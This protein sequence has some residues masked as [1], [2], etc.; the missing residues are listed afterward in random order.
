MSDSGIGLREIKKQMTRESIADAALSLA[1]EKGLEEVTIEEIA[2]LAF[3]SPRTFSNYFSCKE[4]A[5]AT[6][7]TQHNH[8]LFDELAARPQDEAPLRSMATIMVEAVQGLSDEQ[9]AKTASK[10]RLSLQHPSLR[11]FQTA[12]YDAI[13]AGLR[14]VVATRSGTSLERD[15]YPW[16]VTSVA[17]GA[18]RA[19][20]SLWLRSGA[21]RDRLPELMT[22]AFDRVSEGLPAPE[23]QGARGGRG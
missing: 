8:E 21:G 19:A 12:Q 5:V 15:L 7:G 14:E 20:T 1:L 3:V 18:V 4:E 17:V 13:E 11:A 23:H 16:L 6:A 22:A 2:Q 9:L 10:L